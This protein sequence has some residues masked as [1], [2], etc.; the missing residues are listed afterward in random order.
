MLRCGRLLS[1]ATTAAASA[2]TAASASASPANDGAAPPQAAGGNTS[3][4]SAAAAAARNAAFFSLYHRLLKA[5]E[6]GAM[7][8][9]CLTVHRL[10]DSVKY[11]MRLLRLHRGLTTVDAAA[12][13]TRWFH[14]IKRTRQGLARRYYAWS[15]F[16]LRV[17]LRSWNAIADMLVYLLFVTVCVLLYEIYRTCRLGVDRAEERYRTLAIPIVQ[18]FDALEAA[19]QRKVALRKE[20]EDDIVRGR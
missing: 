3:E 13:Q 9:H 15:L 20:M 5:G 8:Q 17:K 19:Q 10:E 16:R 7:M 1:L 11:G 2:A 6:E 18:T 4:S 14:L 12:R